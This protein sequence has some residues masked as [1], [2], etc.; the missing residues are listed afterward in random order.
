MILEKIRNKKILFTYSDPG[1]AKIILALAALLKTKNEIT[2][3]TNRD[4]D[5]ALEFNV[6]YNVVDAKK[7]IEY[8]QRNEFDSLI[9]GTSYTNDFELDIINFCK[10]K[11]I[12]TS[13]FIDNWSGFDVRL[14]RGNKITIPDEVLLIDSKAKKNAIDFGIKENTID[15]IGN[16]YWEYLK[17]WTPKISKT[18]LFKEYDI[19]LKKQT[20]YIAPDPLSNVGGI[21]RFGFDEYAFLNKIIPTININH[22]NVVIKPHPNQ[23]IELL[24]EILLNLPCT[25]ITDNKYHNHLIYYSNLVLSFFS[26]ILIEAKYLDTKPLRYIEGLVSEDLFEDKSIEIYNNKNKIEYYL[27]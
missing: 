10:S 9:S 13:I 25:I 21:A 22:Y 3:L 27:D 23:N 16:P 24:N 20:I 14:K 19:S 7:A 4:Y 6:N 18:Q 5:F 2:I 26:N 11:N 1:G 15:I 17:Q 8:I 12:F